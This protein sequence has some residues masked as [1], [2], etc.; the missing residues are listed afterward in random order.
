M[1]SNEI[2]IFSNLANTVMFSSHAY[3]CTFVIGV[4]R[5]GYCHDRRPVRTCITHCI[6]SCQNYP[7]SGSISMPL[8]KPIEF[9][10]T[11]TPISSQNSHPHS[12]NLFC[13]LFS[14][15]T[16]TMGTKWATKKCDS[17]K[18]PRRS[19]VQVNDCLQYHRHR[20][21]L[22]CINRRKTSI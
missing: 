11:K 21:F 4:A 7:E 3:I 12:E 2:P 9:K 22:H 14:R 13:F 10:N 16:V 5:R 18:F 1:T 15:I 17:F 19:S 8:A 6:C 20:A